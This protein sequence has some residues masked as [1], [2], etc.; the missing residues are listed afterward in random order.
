MHKKSFISSKLQIVKRIILIWFLGLAT[1]PLFSQVL[2]PLGTGLPGRVV[3]SYATDDEYFALYDDVSTSDTTDYVLARWNGAYWSYCPGLKTPAPIIPTEGNYNFHS[4]AYF[5]NT[6]YVGAYLA[7]ASK[8]AEIPVTHLYK[9]NANTQEWDPEVGVVDTRNNGIITMAVFDNKLIIA[10]KFQSTLNGKS[11]QNIAS[12]DG[13][14]WDYLGTSNLDQGADGIIR[15]LMVVGN[16]LY[17]GGDFTTFAGKQTGNI[18]YYTAAN[19]GWGGIGSPF[20]GEILELASW[21]GSQIAALGKD[22]SGNKSV[23]VFNVNWSSKLDFTNFTSAEI[24]TIAGTKSYLLLGGT[25]VKDGNGS[26][27]LRFENDNLAFT[28]NRLQG[29]FRLG[30]RGSGA[31]V[32]GDFNELNTDIR[33]FSSIISESG[34]LTGD[35]FYDFDGDCQRDEGEKGL[36]AEVLKLTN[37][38][39]GE[40]FFTVTDEFGH[41]T[42]GLPQG[43]YTI[44]HKN[45]RHFYH[46]CAGNYATQIRNGKYSYVSLGEYMDPQ[47]KDIE[48]NVEPIYPDELK[49]GD[50]IQALVTVK[51]H[52]ANTLNSATLLISHA[53]PLADFYSEPA[54]DNYDGIEATYSLVNLEPFEVRFILVRYKMPLS[55]NSKDEYNIRVSTGSLI[56][57]QDE[58]QEDNINVASLKIGKRGN[59][60]VVEKNS[61]LGNEIDQKIATWK[62]TIDFKNTSSSKVNKVILVDTL[63]GDLPL[64]RVIVNSFYPQKAQFFIQQGRILVVNFDPANLKTYEASPSNAVGWV[65]YQVDLYQDLALQ[66]KINNIA[67]IDFDSK[68]W[69]VSNDCWVTVVDKQSAVRKLKLQPLD[70]YPNPTGDF[71]NVEWDRTE[72]GSE[73]IIINLQGQRLMEGKIH[74]STGHLNISKLGS[75]LYFLQTPTTTTRFSVVK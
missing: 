74:N 66:T 37:K 17:I 32:W 13:T 7:N 49:A 16:R 72:T 50:T 29:D 19:G 8:D 62:Y 58:T 11:V 28:G 65:K 25:F 55:A 61:V 63:A 30:Q 15:S 5:N 39:T 23:R 27:L 4:I 45:K 54:A 33:F 69:G 57:G 71:L 64:Q 20:I 38:T 56:T 44:Q 12:F 75:G 70:V 22:S 41:F 48:V 10:G 24:K 42:V 2:E 47:T 73:W 40:Y 59:G 68:W 3:A 26:S 1:F 53:L 51:N 14:N 52:G 9:W 31:F 36:P 46:V 67:H 35:L 21:S 6:I 60:G 18:A 43:D 34:N